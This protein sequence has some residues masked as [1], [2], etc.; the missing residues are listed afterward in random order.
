MPLPLVWSW[1]LSEETVSQILLGSIFRWCWLSAPLSAPYPSESSDPWVSQVDD[2]YQSSSLHTTFNAGYFFLPLVLRNHYS[3][4]HDQQLI[5]RVPWQSME[6]HVISYCPPAKAFSLILS[7]FCPHLTL[8]QIFPHFSYFHFIMH[9]HSFS[10]ILR[11]KSPIV[12]ILGKNEDLCILIIFDLKMIPSV[13]TTWTLTKVSTK[14]AEPKQG[15]YPMGETKVASSIKQG[16][17]YSTFW[18]SEIKRVTV[19]YNKHNNY[20]KGTGIT[21]AWHTLWGV[22]S[23]IIH[24]YN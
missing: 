1:S 14:E 21:C 3:K 19:N 24:F 13:G 7:H 22:L 23:I 17:T 8:L 20:T 18:Y 16:T 4:Y 12:K 6:S 2:V 9:H 10:S 11:E 5:S 15:P